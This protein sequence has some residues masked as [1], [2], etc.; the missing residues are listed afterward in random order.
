[1]GW[2]SLHRERGMSDRAFFEREF[3]KGLGRYG[4][5]VTC[6]TIR[7]VFYA[8]VEN[9]ADHPNE[10]GV[11]WALV[12]LLRRTRGHFNFYYKD[13]SETMLPCYY[14]APQAVLDALSP[15]THEDALTWRARCQQ[16][17]D[18]RKRLVRGVTVTFARP[19]PFGD[20][21]E[22]SVLRFVTGTTFEGAAD[23]VLVRIP[24]WQDRDYTIG[25]PATVAA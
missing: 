15:T 10:P 24:N 20:N 18:D 23:G 11:T 6:A 19:I 8:A 17:I 21:V 7:G 9:N 3:P 16:R 2:T 25:E 1:M 12:V 4:R 22:R 14:N 5:I 13:M